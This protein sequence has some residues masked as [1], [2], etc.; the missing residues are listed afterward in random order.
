NVGP[1]ALTVSEQLQAGWT[2]TM[3][4]PPGTYAVTLTSGQSVAG[5]DFGNARNSSVRGMVFY[6]RNSNGT[7]EPGGG[8]LTGVTVAATAAHPANNRSSV[9]QAGGLYTLSLVAADTYTIGLTVKANWS[10]TFPPTAT[11]T[12]VIT[13][14]T[15]TTGLDFGAGTVTDT[16]KFRSIVAD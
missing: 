6:D 10:R 16:A 13:T 5:R 2:Q 11:Y 7:H 1:G 4:G 12:V 14:G 3:P 15:D 9:S 8:G